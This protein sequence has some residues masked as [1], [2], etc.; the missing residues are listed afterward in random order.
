MR[1]IDD[2]FDVH[3]F[4]TV[5]CE[6]GGGGTSELTGREEFRIILVVQFQLRGV[7][8]VE[9]VQVVRHFDAIDR[10]VGPHFE[11]LVF[12]IPARH[13]LRNMSVGLLHVVASAVESVEHDIV[14]FLKCVFGAT[15][16]VALNS[17]AEFSEDKVVMSLRAVEFELLEEL[18]G[19]EGFGGYRVFEGGSDERWDK[20]RRAA[21][22]ELEGGETGGCVDGVHNVEAH[23][24][25]HSDPAFLIAIDVVTKCLHN[26]FVC[27]FASTSVMGW[28]AVDILI[29]VPE[30]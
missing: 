7:K 13:E 22:T 18:F 26:S 27:A 5:L 20:S 11:D 21:H 10:R 29:L 2:P 28:K 9:L 30:I 25:Q 16:L 24:R 6:D 3:L 12:A 14:A 17:L 15:V 8:D 19:M 1:L 23:A 4:N